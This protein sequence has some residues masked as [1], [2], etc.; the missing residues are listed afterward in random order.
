MID[1]S[2]PASPSEVGSY[3]SG[4]AAAYDIAI[5][6]D[7]AYVAYTSNGM[8]ILDLATPASPTFEGEYKDATWFPT[9]VA[10]YGD[11]AY[12]AG[13]GGSP[14]NW[15]VR[16]VDITPPSS[17]TYVGQIDASAGEITDII[18]AGGKAYVTKSGAVQRVDTAPPGLLS[19]YGTGCNTAAGVAVSGSY[20]YVTT[21][22]QLQIATQ[23]SSPPPY[24]IKVSAIG[25]TVGTTDVAAQN[26][27][28][29]IGN[30]TSGMAVLDV[31]EPYT[32]TQVSFGDTNSYGVK[33][34]PKS[35]SMG[36]GYA[37]VGGSIRLYIFNINDPLHPA[38]IDTLCGGAI[39]DSV[40]SGS[41][42]YAAVP[43]YF[44]ICDLTNLANI[45]WESNPP[46][47]SAWASGVAVKGNT[48]YLAD[49][50]LGMRI[51]NI[52]NTS[53][54]TQLGLYNPAGAKYFTDV[55]VDGNVA[56]ITDWY[57]HKLHLVNVSNPASPA[58][59]G[60][61]ASSDD[62]SALKIGRNPWIGADKRYAFI[63][64]GWQGARLL[65]VT[66]PVSPT[67]L[68]GLSDLGF[69]RDI[70]VD[71][72]Y[73][74]ITGDDTGVNL[75]WALRD[76]VTA[77]ITSGGG[78]LVSNLG[79]AQINFPSGAFSETV[80]VVYRRLWTD[81]LTGERSGIGHTFDLRAIY[82]D[83]GRPASL[84]PGISFTR[85]ARATPIPAQSVRIR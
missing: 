37:F 12:L 57:G 41:Y 49:S 71:G 31:S 42:L 64:D 15:R 10:V 5:V 11:Y 22:S 17:P 50:E 62:M 76:V 80:K 32:P 72:S 61:F 65:D 60:E 26:G 56:Y 55:E 58:K 53:G 39:N 84:Q 48:A 30:G 66:N 24:F 85:S 73:I 9:Q 4:S 28:A 35:I 40:L 38:S 21:V 74:Y 33:D 52:S 70:A 44:A 63:A 2:T 46:A 27:Y 83:D 18:Y 36:G 13:Y 78:S 82:A 51:Y 47:A 29:Y 20:Y 25:T 43:E 69:T 8:V 45:H 23:N 6:G 54:V 3:K 59:L 68:A 16:W 79:D 34:K 14:T 1:I 7:Y 67:Q 75:L 81:Q 19:I 77:T